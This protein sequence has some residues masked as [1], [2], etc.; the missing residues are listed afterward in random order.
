MRPLSQAAPETDPKVLQTLLKERMEFHNNLS[1]DVMGKLHKVCAQ[2]TGRGGA[3][4]AASPP[5][6]GEYN[7]PIT[8]LHPTFEKDSC[9]RVLSPKERNKK[10]RTSKIGGEYEYFFPNVEV[11][12]KSEQLL[13]CGEAFLSLRHESDP[14]KIPVLSFNFLPILASKSLLNPN[15]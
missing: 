9:S 10:R 15:Q 6:C 4:E 7:P 3:N 14:K 11:L 5:L 8:A 13:L 1:N 12:K 2:S